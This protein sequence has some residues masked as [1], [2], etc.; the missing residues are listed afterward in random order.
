[1]IQNLSHR[2]IGW[3][4]GLISFAIVGCSGGGDNTPEDATS[5]AAVAGE[6]AM[7]SAP[8][9]ADAPGISPAYPVSSIPTFPTEHI[10]SKGFFFVGG[11]YVGDP[12]VMGG[13][14]YV[15]VWVP[16]E[17]VQPYPLVMFHGNGQTGVDWLQTPDGRPGWAYYLVEQGYTLYMVDYPARG[18]SAFK[19]KNLR[20]RQVTVHVQTPLSQNTGER[21]VRR[22]LPRR[23]RACR[24]RWRNPDDRLLKQWWRRR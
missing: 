20:L 12:P 8:A 18:R 19:G 14:M 2:P 6:T 10:A 21:S 5:D 22:R 24:R 9:M 16:A 11:E 17:P 13:Q 1:M 3:L 7:D 23:R 15:E 4:V